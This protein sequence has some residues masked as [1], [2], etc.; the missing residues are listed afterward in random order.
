LQKRAV[1]AGAD[2]I[3]WIT[4]WWLGTPTGAALRVDQY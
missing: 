2:L 1:K 4:I 3:R